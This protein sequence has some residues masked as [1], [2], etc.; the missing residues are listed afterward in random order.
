MMFIDGDDGDGDDNGGDA[1]VVLGFQ[2]LMHPT[3]LSPLPSVYLRHNYQYVS[4]TGL[5]LALQ[6]RQAWNF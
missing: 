6:P 5:E 3:D 1:F 4:Q 2:G